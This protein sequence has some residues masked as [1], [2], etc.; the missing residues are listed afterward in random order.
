MTIL[1]GACRRSTDGGWAPMFHQHTPRFGVRTGSY[2]DSGQ[3][4]GPSIC[5]PPVWRPK[6]GILAFAD[7]ALSIDTWVPP[8]PSTP[9]P[10]LWG[11]PK[12]V[13]VPGGRKTRVGLTSIS[14]VLGAGRM[15]GDDAFPPLSIHCVPRSAGGQNP[16]FEYGSSPPRQ[17]PSL[18]V[19]ALPGARSGAGGHGDW[20]SF[21]TTVSGHP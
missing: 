19:S 4:C 20:S 10:D 2:P 16:L 9:P 11:P 15:R 12:A 5:P 3:Y 6:S 21:P 18:R 13:K 14:G 7:S 17:A 8:T 1:T